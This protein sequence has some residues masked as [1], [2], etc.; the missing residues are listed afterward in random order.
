MRTSR[1]RSRGHGSAGPLESQ[2]AKGFFLS[3][4]ILFSELRLIT[5]IPTCFLYP[6]P[7]KRFVSPLCQ[8]AVACAFFRYPLWALDA[9]PPF[10]DDCPKLAPFPLLV[11][12]FPFPSHVLA[13]TNTRRFGPLLLI[14]IPFFLPSRCHQPIF[15]EFQACVRF[16]FL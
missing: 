13:L 8:S 16:P 5:V 1:Q 7:P 3:D 11:L 12:Y 14:F 6:L 10:L 15:P 4:S 9:P 2:C